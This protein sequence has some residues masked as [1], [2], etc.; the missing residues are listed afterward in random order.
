MVLVFYPFAYRA[1]EIAKFIIRM[2]FANKIAFLLDV[3]SSWKERVC[4]VS[5]DGIEACRC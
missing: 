3:S 2:L 4:F 5:R 1:Q